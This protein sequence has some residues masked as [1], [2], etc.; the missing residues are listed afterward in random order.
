MA[1]D[2]RDGM[3]LL[4][5]V[6]RMRAAAAAGRDAIQRAEAAL[7]DRRTDDVAAARR[8]FSAAKEALFAAAEALECRRYG[9]WLEFAAQV[10][11]A[12]ALLERR[13]EWRDGE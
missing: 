6:K 9:P 3:T 4:D 8:E 11:G 10:A 7:D 13:V 12:T 5:C 1:Q 2:V